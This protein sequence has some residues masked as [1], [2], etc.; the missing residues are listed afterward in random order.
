MSKGLFW[1]EVSYLSAILFGPHCQ[2]GHEFL[3]GTGCTVPEA[4]TK[5][6]NILHRA[7]INNLRHVLRCHHAVGRVG[8]LSWGILSV[9][10]VVLGC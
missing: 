4:A 7:K 5:P 9:I 6:H 1:E 8:G 3:H 10:R 2:M